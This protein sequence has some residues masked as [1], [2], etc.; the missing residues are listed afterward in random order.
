MGDLQVVEGE[1]HLRVWQIL[2]GLLR[3]NGTQGYLAKRLGV[4]LRG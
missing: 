4:F 1:G 2:A 3:N